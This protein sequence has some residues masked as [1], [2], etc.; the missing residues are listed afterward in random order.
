MDGEAAFPSVERDIQVRELFT[1]G[2]RGDLLSYSRNT[3]KNTECHLKLKD[4]LSRRIQEYKG[5]RLGHVRASGHFKV[6]INP[7]L[8]SLS[9]SNLG[10]HFGPIC[11]TA[12]CIADDTYLFSNS[13]SGLQGA[14][15][16]MSHYADC[17]QLRFNAGKT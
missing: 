13:P 6:Y 2:E 9:S 14:L 15:D 17:Y 5:N 1:I 12:V 7:C 3:Y 11:T 4:K 16:I 8:I 10:F